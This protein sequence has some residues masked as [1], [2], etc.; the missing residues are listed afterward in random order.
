VTQASVGDGPANPYELPAWRSQGDGLM[1]PGGL[2][3]TDRAVAACALAP[4]SRVWDIGCGLGTTVAHLV[5]RHGL[6]ATGADSSEELLEAARRSAPWL[7]LVHARGDALPCASGALDAVL[8]ECSWS[9]MSSGDDAGAGP[10]RVLAELARVV[11][12]GGWL[13]LADLYAR[14]MAGVDAPILGGAC[15]RTMPTEAEVRA[16]VSAAG[17]AIDPWEDHSRALGELSARLIFEHGTL[18]PLWGGSCDRAPDRAALAAARPGYFL[19]TAR[20]E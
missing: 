8:A 1:R 20:R 18:A 7:S 9:A 14:G 2:E 15:W 6:D 19:L 4:G 3:L 12:P 10:D 16:A 5:R 17:F 11:R 13:M